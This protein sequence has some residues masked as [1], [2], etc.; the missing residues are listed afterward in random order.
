[1]NPNGISVWTGLGSVQLSTHK[2]R[3]RKCVWVSACEC[4][5]YWY[6]MS[7]QLFGLTKQ[8]IN[9]NNDNCCYKNSCKCCHTSLHTLTHTHRDNT[10]QHPRNT[11][12]CQNWLLH[13]VVHTSSNIG[14]QLERTFWQI[15]WQLYA[16]KQHFSLSP[17]PFFLPFSLCLLFSLQFSTVYGNLCVLL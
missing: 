10:A 17:P 2:E 4:C 13:S 3:E 11:R 14:A 8:A 9:N 16:K 15:I 5:E 12:T 7:M 6:S 1:M